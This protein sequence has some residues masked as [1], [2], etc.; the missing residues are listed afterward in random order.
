MTYISIRRHHCLIVTPPYRYLLLLDE[1]SLENPDK[2]EDHLASDIDVVKWKCK[3][4]NHVWN[5]SISHRT[6]RKYD[7]GDCFQ[8]SKREIEYISLQY[9]RD[10]PNTSG[11]TLANSLNKNLTFILKKLKVLVGE[12]KLTRTKKGKAFFYSIT[13]DGIIE[14][15]VFSKLLKVKGPQFF[16]NG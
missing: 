11:Q 14:I 3:I 1:W 13:D 10:N 5:C 15:E 7:C 8:R 2:P 16:H 4:C 6:I 9:I 12:G